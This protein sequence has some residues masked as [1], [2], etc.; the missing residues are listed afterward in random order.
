[1]FN[2]SLTFIVKFLLKTN[3]ILCRSEVDDLVGSEHYPCGL[4]CQCSK[5]CDVV[6]WGLGTRVSSVLSYHPLVGVGASSGLRLLHL[7]LRLWPADGGW[8]GPAA[9]P[10]GQDRH[11]SLRLRVV[12]LTFTSGADSPAV[13]ADG[14]RDV[15]GGGV[16]FLGERTVATSVYRRVLVSRETP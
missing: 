7:L 6:G 14:R 5:A 4:W 8:G 12:F 9:I 2:R 3:T 11:V 15:A 13:S 1:M 10:G 16:G